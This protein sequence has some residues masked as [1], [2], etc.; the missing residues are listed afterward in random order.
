MMSVSSSRTGLDNIGQP[1]QPKTPKQT[2]P[3]VT[4]TDPQPTPSSDSNSGEAIVVE[5]KPKKSRFWTKRWFLISAGIFVL[6]VVA[7]GAAAYM[8]FH[9]KP[10]PVREAIATPKPTPSATPP[11]V[12]DPLTGLPTT[13]AAAQA[14]VIGVMIENLYPQARPQSGLG[15][16]GLVYEAL[17]EGGITRFE[18]IFQEP[19]PASIGPVRSLRP[20]F[21]DFGLEHSIPVVHAGGSQPA[22]AE[23]GPLG[24]KDINALR[25]DGSFFYRISS[26]YAPH[27][28]YTNAQD[29]TQLDSNLG[30]A[31]APTFTPFT[32]KSDQATANPTHPVIDVTYSSTPYNVE[33]KYVQ[34]CDCYARLMGGA[35]HVDANTNQQINAKNVIV[36]F[37]STSYGTQADGDPMTIM[38]LVGSGKALLFN[39]G[40]LVA[41]SWS[42]SSD[43]AQTQYT[44]ASG[45]PIQLNRGDTWIDVVPTT[46][47]VQY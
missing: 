25:Y 5:K 13:T 34:G 39:D 21:L 1:R 10:Q 8:V 37:V 6:L 40:G 14:P 24:L 45:K 28:L 27:N 31:T 4:E 36:E 18:A 47:T 26:R 7:G 3:E 38:Q 30:F 32:Y 15:T 12:Y 16:A 11:P 23:I 43:A 33:W 46:A 17:A 22:L 41:G 29:L 35:P 20:Y 19:L 9:K 44:D 42:K 2:K